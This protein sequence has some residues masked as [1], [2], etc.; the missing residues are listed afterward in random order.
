MIFLDFKGWYN[1]MLIPT[2]RSQVLFLPSVLRNYA[3]VF[4][5]HVKVVTS[6]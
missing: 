6:R 3:V 1:Y 2:F 5:D 4:S